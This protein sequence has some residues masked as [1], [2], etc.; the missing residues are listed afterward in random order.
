MS[1]F[2]T[3]PCPGCGPA[4]IDIEHVVLRI[5]EDTDRATISVRCPECG[6]R[7]VKPVDD[8]MSVL[9]VTV[10]VEVQTWTRPAEVDERPA[11][12]PPITPDELEAFARALDQADD[13]ERFA[14]GR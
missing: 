1:S 14:S 8:G 10:G 7:F 4:E 2:I 11:N 12:L 6:A 5:D 13:L 9:L 3:T